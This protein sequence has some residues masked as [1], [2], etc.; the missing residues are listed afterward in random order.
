MGMIRK[1]GQRHEDE[2]GRMCPAMWLYSPNPG[3]RWEQCETIRTRKASWGSEWKGQPWDEETGLLVL[4][5]FPTD[6]LGP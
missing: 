2:R 1:K 6:C 5:P 3:G 4:A